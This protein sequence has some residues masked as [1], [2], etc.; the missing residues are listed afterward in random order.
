M[1]GGIEDVNG[2]ILNGGMLWREAVRPVCSQCK[3]LGREL[4]GSTCGR[5]SQD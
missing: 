4:S 3:T 5:D 1:I 2:R